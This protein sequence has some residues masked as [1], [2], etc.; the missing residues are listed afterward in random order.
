MTALME[1]AL[2][3]EILALPRE[4]RRQLAA[5]LFDSLREDGPDEVELQAMLHSRSS[6]L[7]EGRDPGMSFEEIFGEPA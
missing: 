2:A 5:L 1:S 4:E 3:G 6:D 7:R